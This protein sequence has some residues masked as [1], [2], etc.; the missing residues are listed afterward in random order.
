MPTLE[1]GARSP[2]SRA[3]NWPSRCANTMLPAPRIRTRVSGSSTCSRLSDVTQTDSSFVA[4]GV[5][6]LLAVL[7]QGIAHHESAGESFVVGV[8]AVANSIKNREDAGSQTSGWLVLGQIGGVN[9]AAH[10]RQRWIVERIGFQQDL[11][12][13]P[14]AA[15]RQ[16]RAAHVERDAV[17]AAHITRARYELKRC[18]RIHELTDRPRRGNAVDV[19]PLARNEIHTSS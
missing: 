18:I 17:H 14:T 13:A 3:A 16:S 15:M 5:L 6:V 4:V 10:V 12:C 7:I 8:G 2:R 19:D 1:A 9:D 11:E